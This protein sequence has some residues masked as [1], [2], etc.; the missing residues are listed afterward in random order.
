MEKITVIC[1]ALCVAH[2][3]TFVV[4]L[5]MISKFYDRM[6]FPEYCNNTQEIADIS[7]TVLHILLTF[8]CL[9]I[10]LYYG[11][12][13]LDITPIRGMCIYMILPG[14]LMLIYD[15][16]ADKTELLETLFLLLNTSIAVGMLAPAA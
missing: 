10:M 8:G 1:I 9:S 4:R 5:V 16:V 6:G 12:K 7:V 11:Y 15:A 3:I 2:F 14:L 13:G